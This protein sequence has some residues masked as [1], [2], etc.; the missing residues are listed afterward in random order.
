MSMLTPWSTAACLISKPVT[1]GSVSE[2][3]FLLTE[4]SKGFVSRSGSLVIS[5]FYHL[6]FLL[7]SIICPWFKTRCSA[8]RDA[9]P[10]NGAS[11]T[12]G[13]FRLEGRWLSADPAS[14]LVVLDDLR[15]DSALEAIFPTRREVTFFRATLP[16]TSWYRLLR[17]EWR[18]TCALLDYCHHRG[19]FCG[20]T[21]YEVPVSAGFDNAKRPAIATQRGV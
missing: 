12:E 3:G 10:S 2:T 15:L 1:I 19:A 14:D 5:Y 9:G 6:M 8:N 20:C 18:S 4:I 16:L 21:G 13:Y 11:L 7:K 17:N